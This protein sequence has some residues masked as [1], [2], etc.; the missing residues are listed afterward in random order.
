[1][2]D[3]RMLRRAGV[4]DRHLGAHGQRVAK[5]VM[6][7]SAASRTGIPP[8]SGHQ[9]ARLEPQQSTLELFGDCKFVRHEPRFELRQGC[10]SVDVR[11][12]AHSPEPGTSR[13]AE[14][15]A[16]IRF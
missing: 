10:K 11:L 12:R 3:T 16:P 9:V 8:S 7:R 1:M 14:L 13:H 4:V 6:C 2:I 15:G 5:P